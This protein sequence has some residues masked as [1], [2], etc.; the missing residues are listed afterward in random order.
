MGVTVNHLQGLMSQNLRQGP[1]V[2]PGHQEMAGCRVA[3][4]ME[5]N[6]LESRFGS[7]CFK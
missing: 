1:D 4:V 5:V 7:G 2:Y 3:Q 6:V